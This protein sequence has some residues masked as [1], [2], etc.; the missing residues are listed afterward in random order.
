MG[1]TGGAGV[2]EY[3]G[4]DKPGEQK[5]DKETIFTIKQ[6]AADTHRALKVKSGHCL[7]LREALM[8]TC[9]Q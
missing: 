1:K 6:T 4:G 9:K 7:F 3:D 2:K 5:T 8:Q